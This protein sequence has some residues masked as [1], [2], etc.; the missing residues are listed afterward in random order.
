M[1]YDAKTLL[2]DKRSL[3][4]LLLTIFGVWFKL[5][6]TSVPEVKYLTRP[7]TNGTCVFCKVPDDS[8][9]GN[10]KTIELAAPDK[11]IAN[12]VQYTERHEVWVLTS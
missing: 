12:Y 1:T 6:S 2:S 10:M 8:F 4:I 5:N 7:S 3:Y 11:D 9:Y